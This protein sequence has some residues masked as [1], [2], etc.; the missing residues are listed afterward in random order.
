MSSYSTAPP[1]DPSP[2][3]IKALLIHLAGADPKAFVH[4]PPSES[5]DYAKMGFTVLIPFTLALTGGTYTLYTLQDAPK[6]MMAALPFGVVWALMI[7]GM[8][9]AIMSQLAKRSPVISAP[10]PNAYRQAYSGAQQQTPPPPKASSGTFRRLI[11][12]LLRIMIA[13]TL[14]LVMSH[15]L[16]LAI[17]KGRVHSR[18]E[19]VR[20]LQ[21]AD[22]E[23]KERPALE[24]KQHQASSAIRVQ[25]LAG[26]DQ[27]LSAYNHLQVELGAAVIPDS[28]K[29]NTGPD[30]T[31]ASIT[32]TLKPYEDQI[33]QLN[34]VAEEKSNAV[35]I[36]AKEIDRMKEERKQ[37]LKVY[38]NERKGIAG[39]YTWYT[40]PFKSGM[41]AE[42]SGIKND[43][44]DEDGPRAEF[45]KTRIAEADIH[46]ATQQVEL[47][48]MQKLAE[49]A[50]NEVRAAVDRKNAAKARMLD[51]NTAGIEGKLK[52]YEASQQD[53]EKK[54]RAEI[55]RIVAR[56]TKERDNAEQQYNIRFKPITGVSYDLLEQT[57]ALHD[58]ALGNTDEAKGTK[59]WTILGL[60]ILI[61]I[62]LMFID[63]TPLMMKIMHP[64]GHYDA[65]V[66][67]PLA[68]AQDMNRRQD[69]HR[70]PPS[71][72]QSQGFS[73]PPP[74]PPPRRR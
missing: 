2:R 71:S 44:P 24:R 61:L 51:N 30:T 42:T 65:F 72:G 60:I 21:R 17:F 39:T 35:L 70:R 73:E 26:R 53:T 59:Q 52:A 32:A 1:D 23:A 49:S 6:N 25:G 27:F 66:A 22:V 55:E 12:A 19:D 15:C 40:A 10:P 5:S 16:V 34:S 28:A 36:K 50:E 62:C 13:G 47:D 37:A 54:A 11:L 67:R 56:L 45:I 18:I 58:L 57:E 3:G 31:E 68:P 38:D 64:P 41:P 33:T 69:D 74:P 9:V 4:L 63:L 43:P 8:D 20:S 29:Q 14:G 46:I 7:L 48:Q